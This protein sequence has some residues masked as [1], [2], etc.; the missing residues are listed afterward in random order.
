M[1]SAAVLRSRRRLGPT[2]RVLLTPLASAS[3]AASASPS[4]SASASASPSP[5]QARAAHALTKAGLRAHEHNDR[6]LFKK[7][8]KVRTRFTSRPCLSL[9]LILSPT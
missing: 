9:S 4:A 3:P 1:R 2:R 6:R 8:E 5:S 7:K